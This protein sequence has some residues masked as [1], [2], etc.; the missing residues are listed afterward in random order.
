LIYLFIYLF[1]I[2][3][4]LYAILFS[5][6][7]LFALSP[8]F[9]L[10]GDTQHPTQLLEQVLLHATTHLRR[11]LLLLRLLLLLVNLH[12]REGIVGT[13]LGNE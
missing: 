12:R 11:S 7:L 13:Q 2:L 1:I 3:I 5:I 10:G 8:H 6:Q 4:Y 9:F